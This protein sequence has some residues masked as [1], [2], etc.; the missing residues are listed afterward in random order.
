MSHDDD[1]R[2]AIR[3]RLRDTM[4]VEAGAGTGKTRALVDRVVALVAS[5]VPIERIAAITFTERAAAELRDRV[6]SGLEEA[7][8]HAGNLIVSGLCQTAL[9]GLD[10]AQLSTIHSFAQGLLRAYA[11]E[12]GV[13]PELTVLDDLAAGLRFDERWRAALEGMDPASP[14]GRAIDRALGLGLRIDGLRTL[15]RRLQ[16]RAD[17][18]AAV[19]ADPPSAPAPDWRALPDLRA[20]VAGVPLGRVVGDDACLAHLVD[21]AGAL[22]DLLAADGLDREAVL[23]GTASLHDKKCTR[24]GNQA[25]WTGAAVP[26]EAARSTAAAVG[27][28]LG[29][30]LAQARAEALADLL[31]PVAEVMLAEAADR[32]REGALVFDDLILWA[33]DLLRDSPSARAALRARYDA[34]LID[35]FQD[36]DPWQASIA[37]SFARA[38]Q[39]APLDP[40][41]LFLVGDP[42]QSIYRFRR[43]DMAVYAAEEAAVRAEGGLLPTLRVN[44]RTRDVILDWVNEVFAGLIG[45]GADPALQPA[46]VPVDAARSAPLRGPGVAWMG[47]PTSDRAW[48]MRRAEARDVAATCRAAVAEGWEVQEREGTVRPARLGD[49]AV[50]IPTRT[51]L[52]AIEEAMRDTGVAYRVEGGSLVY[53]T[54]ELR[55]LLNQLTAIDDPSDEVAVVAALRG[56]GFACSDLELAAHRAQ[57]RRFN[58]LAPD[59]D[60]PGPVLEGLRRLR[61]HHRARHDRPLAALVERV[62]ADMRLVEVGMVHRRTRDAYRRARFVVEQA[63]AFES[64]R[65]RSMRAFVEW[66][67]ERT[68]GPV[69]DREGSGLDDDEDAVRVLTVHAAKGLEFPVVIVAGI[70]TKPQ[71]VTPPVVSEHE[72][73]LVAAVGTKS[74]GRLELGD[75]ASVAA[76]E[77]Q[78]RDAEAARLLY[79]AVTRARDH[80]IVSLRHSEK[81]GRDSGAWRLIQSGAVDGAERWEPPDAPAAAGADP[82]A[83]LAVDL[84]EAPGGHAAAR[85]ALAEGAR[86]VRYTS[87]TA[88]AAAAEEAEGGGERRAESDEPWSRGRGG[89]RV[90]RA[91]HA[92]IQSL[93][94]TATPDEV[95][96]VAAAQAVAEAVPDRA[97]EVAA[98]VA[99]A[100]G[101]EAAGRARAAAGALREV[102]FALARDGAVVEGFIDLVVPAGGGLEIIDWKTDDVPPARV[103]ERLGAYRLQAGLYAAGLAEATGMP[104]ERITYV[105]LRAGVEESP[106]DPAVLADHAMTQIANAGKQ[107]ASP[108]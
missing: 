5:G 77:T 12:A 16:E 58:Y 32:R 70:G 19:V 9:D 49:I 10:R 30:T 79:V 96:A 43:A 107:E 105:F 18:A 17:I 108:E 24:L 64:D 50:L 73:R 102:P 11:A 63:R 99:A 1:A 74:G 34:L 40:G 90:G 97:D 59:L 37:E 20:A 45:D 13:D 47:E 27:A 85:A 33:R 2:T 41:R 94:L 21:L 93:P 103:P 56:P 104:V 35:E 84:P 98:L 92:A 69:L 26:L 81:Y 66:L 6:R 62:V 51:G 106:G 61:D 53:R 78:H 80:L 75:V 8:A 28:A 3:E 87:A 95:A 83:G 44:R 76:R 48:D 36:T 31:P 25:N 60:G 82:L 15:A 57:G 7:Q 68:G 100:L 67:E 86:R 4:L 22:D 91:V 55:D 89:S 38:A 52:S 23:A 42:K 65:P 101:S 71:N 29:G 14:A 88:M 39:G 72:G 54:Q 46:Y